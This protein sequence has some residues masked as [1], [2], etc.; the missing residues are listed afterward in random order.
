MLSVGVGWRLAFLI[1]PVLGVVILFVRR[2]LPESPRWQLTPGRAEEAERTIAY[3]EDEVQH[4]GRSLPPVDTSKAI[5][6]HPTER[7]GYAA[8]VRVLFRDYPKRAFTASA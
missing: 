1:G 6:L 2:R 3:I 5:V 4:G 7:I 8:L